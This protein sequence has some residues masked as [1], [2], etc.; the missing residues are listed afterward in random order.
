VVARCGAALRGW[1]GRWA[2]PIFLLAFWAVPGVAAADPAD[3]L[4]PGHGTVVPLVDCVR[5]GSGGALTVVLGYSNSGTATEHLRGAENR[6]SPA[7]LDGGQPTKFSSGTHH[8]VFTL[9]VAAGQAPGGQVSW[10][11]DGTTVVAGSGS[12]AC[13]AG[14]DLPADGNGTGP[15][16]VL[17]L[18]GVVGVLAVL[19][20]RRRVAALAVRTPDRPADGGPQQP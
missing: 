7:A 10:T 4:T 8:G 12:P 20:A 16:I 3:G 17:A 19:R 11:L 1:K 14:S 9:Q 6:I 15:V 18:A 2:L 13:P 5:T